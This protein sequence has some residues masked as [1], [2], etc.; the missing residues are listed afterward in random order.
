MFDMIPTI[1]KNLFSKP[2]TRNYPY[3]VREDFEGARGK[4]DISIEDCIFCGICSRKCPVDCI[5]VSKADATWEIDPY[6]CITCNSCVES[7]PKKCLTMNKQRTASV[8]KKKKIKA[9]RETPI[10]PPVKKEV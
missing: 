1:M 8:Y 6:K 3:V 10:A 5:N 4:I 9:H 2:A 7:C